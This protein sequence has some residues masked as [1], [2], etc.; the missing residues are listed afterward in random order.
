MAKCIE[1]SLKPK[2]EGMWAQKQPPFKQ[3]VIADPPRFRA[4]KMDG[5]KSF[6]DISDVL[7]RER[8]KE[9]SG[10]GRSVFVRRCG[11]RWKEDPA[12]S[13]IQVG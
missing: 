10:E 8:G 9:A 7:S 12:G 1:G 2:T 13:S 3:R 4:L 5:T 6:T 11:P